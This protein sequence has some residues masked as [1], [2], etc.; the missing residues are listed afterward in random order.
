MVH[1]GMTK[2]AQIAVTR[3]IAESVAG[4]GMTANSI[5]AGRKGILRARA[6][7]VS[8]KALCHRRGSRSHGYL[9]GQRAFFSNERSR[10]ASRWRRPEGDSEHRRNEN[11]A[12][13]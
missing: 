4:T 3:G 12:F 5:L 2:T 11:V 1:Y 6:A 7:I 9:R 10:L 8:A 13:Y